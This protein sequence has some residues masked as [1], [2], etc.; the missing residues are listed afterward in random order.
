[1]SDVGKIGTDHL[2]RSAVVYIRQSTQDQV[3][4]NRE[5]RLRQYGLKEKAERLGFRDVRVID[6]DLGKSASGSVSRPGFEALL[7]EVCAGKVG[8]VFAIEASRL[9]RN[10]R[11]WHTLLE[12]CGLMHTLIVDHDG[13]YDPRSPNDR[14]LLGMKGT[15]SEMELTVLRQRS[16]EALRQKAMRGELLTTVAVGY[17][18][19]SG[20]RIEQDP[21]LRVRCAIDLVF[22]KFREL[23]S[24]RQVLLWLRH[25]SIQLPA[26]ISVDGERKVEWKLP[27]YN[28]VH[29]ILTN[30]VYAGAYA[31]G[32]TFTEL[33]VVDGQGKKVAGHRRPLPSWPILIKDH[34]APYIQWQEYERNQ[35][36]IGENANMKGAMTRGSVKG[37]GALLAGI[38]R[39]GHCGRKL[40]V[41]Y[42]GSRGTVVR[43]GCRGAQVNHGT[44]RCISL[45]A[46]KIERLVVGKI[47]E[48]LSPLA[49][50]AADAAL[51]A[52]SGEQQQKREQ[53]GLAIEQARYKAHRAQRQYDL[54]EPENRLVVVELESRWNERLAEVRR[55]E[56]ELEG[57]P[58]PTEALSDTE[59][60]QLSSWS[61]DLG[62]LWRDP[63]A[64]SKLKKRIIRTVV[65]EIVVSINGVEVT[66]IIHW[67]G[68]DHS[69]LRFE[70]NRAGTHRWSTDADTRSLI[71]E[72]ARLTTDAGIAVTLN[73]L[74]RKTAKGNSWNTMRVASFR[75]YDGIPSF[76]PRALTEAGEILLEDAA[77]M[78]GIPRLRLYKL[79]RQDLIPARQACPGAPWVL[80]IS[81]VERHANFGPCAS[82]QQP[83]FPAE[84]ST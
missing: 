15:I 69:R 74:G 16:D 67:A 20:D 29:H 59:R 62:A 78:V 19:A 33:C 30:P 54:A 17:V 58:A 36:L 4:H 53:K 56:E 76:D 12:L 77:K 82:G 51:R 40:H 10:G 84:S 26:A 9:A 11:E 25:G 37:G 47:L 27:I 45:G 18:R 63:R 49:L 42:S 2:G 65:K 64:D 39:C 66:A 79:I 80:K 38:L 50:E 23:G 46:M 43:Y 7:S 81:D 6:D 32:R 22:E 68:G 61:Q 57:M 5:S 75:N 55:L 72:L 31:F 60:E 35:T 70:K 14:L 8:A 34:H 28:S 48:A 21:D 41:C 24:V 71:R 1:M 83:L 73:R 44:G 3:L 52:R 13:A